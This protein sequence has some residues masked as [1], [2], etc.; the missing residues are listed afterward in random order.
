MAESLGQKQRRFAR[1]IVKLLSE[2]YAAGYEVS[3][4]EVKRSDEQAEINAL[5][6]S[7]RSRVCELVR[8][9]FPLLSAKIDNN[10]KNNGVRNSTHTLQ[11][12]ID[13]NLFKDGK[14]LSQ[15]EDHRKFGELWESYDAD[16]RWGGRFRDGNHYSIEH[17]GVK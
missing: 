7:G 3:F 10:G 11:L 15:T 12:A 2:I 5:G 1:L 14:Y 13:L 9:E 17:Q 4:G 8:G 16:C 6:Y